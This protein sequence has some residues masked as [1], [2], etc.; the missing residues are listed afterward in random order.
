MCVY[1]C[2]S[3]SVCESVAELHTTDVV[4]RSCPESIKLYGNVIAHEVDPS[5]TVY[6]TSVN[7]DDG[8][9][10]FLLNVR[11]A[12]KTESICCKWKINNSN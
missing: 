8:C 6:S 1:D 7:R 9:L 12:D 5:V 11:L 3:V 4:Y 10:L 2:V